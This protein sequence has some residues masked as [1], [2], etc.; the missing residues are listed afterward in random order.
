M[1]KNFN[2]GNVIKEKHVDKAFQL[3]KLQLR[4]TNFTF[5][6]IDLQIYRKEG[7]I[8]TFN[9]SQYYTK[10]IQKDLLYNYPDLFYINQYAI[11]KGAYGLRRFHFASFN[12]IVL[13][14]SLGFYFYE[15]VND[16]LPRIEL[17]KKRL[18]NIKT[19][20]G[21]SIN[22]EHPDKSEIYYQSDYIQ[23]NQGVKAVIKQG[24]NKNRKVAIVKLDI[25]DFYDTIDTSLL[26]EAIEKY[27]LPS[28][29][30][31]LSYDN[32]TK[33]LIHGLFLFLNKTGFG[34]PLSAQNIISNFISYI[35]L[36]EL[37]NFVQHQKF[38]VQSGFNYYRYVDDFF[39]ILHRDITL[40]N[41]VIGEEIF[42]ISSNITNFLHT[43]LK[44]KI[45]HLKSQKWIVETESDYNDF[46][47]EEKFISFVDPVKK[48]GI[49]PQ[50]KINEVC[51]IIKKLKDEFLNSGKTDINNDDDVALKEV[52]VGSIKHYVK[53]PE[54]IKSL[55]EAF[56]N[57]NPILTLN[58]V[59]ALMFLIGNSN[60]GYR[61]IKDYL[62]NNFTEKMSK[63]QNVYL[64]EKFLNLDNYDNSLNELILNV[65]KPNSFYYSLVQ[66][67]I[68]G[69]L[70]Q[71]KVCLP[72]SDLILLT[73]DSLMQQLKMMVLAQEEGKYNL[74][75]NHMLNV[76][77]MLCFI[78]DN[79]KA[80]DKLKN[81][82]QNDIV[83]YLTT[84]SAS[85]DEINFVMSFFDRRNKNNI[86]HPGEELME[87]WVVNETEYYSYYQQLYKL[88]E[89][90]IVY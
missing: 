83:D 8:D 24:I 48:M 28:T 15:L 71:A 81:Y 39:I 42:N 30:K 41:E 51:D 67:M 36:F 16:S 5:K 32:T 65:N 2:I 56:V 19:Y 35:F 61:L 1:T 3:L 31:R 18:N 55:D 50:E 13:Y 77:H 12:L 63:I 84:K 52:F 73:N 23:F 45:N 69:K 53:S 7:Y 54:A 57:W 80:T 4:E 25:Q 76:F 6:I 70:D 47:I 22:F 88:I 27:S 79:N 14:Y 58:S 21:G 59:K 86:S 68:N 87:N 74:A 33:E 85:I 78:S 66:R 26:L 90:K 9:V 49:S 40:S 46:L 60:V 64:L 10:F 11:P 17:F 20:Y 29:K 72:I 37:D 34:L 75:F 62:T 82:D 38:Y 43:Q 44:L 89:R